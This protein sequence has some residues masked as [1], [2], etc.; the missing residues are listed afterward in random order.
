MVSINLDAWNS[1]TGEQQQTIESLAEKM[2]PKF[3]QI[4]HDEDARNAKILADHGIH[5]SSPSAEL[6]RQLTQAAQPQWQAFRESAGAKADEM[7][8]KYLEAR[9]AK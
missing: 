6:S 1:L 9:D 3:Q 4:S 5:M 8:T 7:M 2:E